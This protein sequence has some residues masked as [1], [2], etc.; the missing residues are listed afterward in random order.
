[1]PLSWFFGGNWLY[2]QAYPDKV[3][4]IVFLDSG[5]PEY[6]STDSKLFAKTINRTAA[7]VRKFGVLLPMYGE[8]IRN[9]QLPDDLKD[10]DKTIMVP[11]I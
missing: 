3:A 6:Y 5:S 2:A 11:V 4:G 1:M 7:F 8:N 9:Q 10:L